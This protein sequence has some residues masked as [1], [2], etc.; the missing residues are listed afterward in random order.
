MDYGKINIKYDDL[1]LKTPS[2]KK[3]TTHDKIFLVLIS[4]ILGIAAFGFD[5]ISE[6][7]V[8]VVKRIDWVMNS[9]YDSVV[10]QN[11]VQIVYSLVALLIPF[12]IG[13]I[14][15]KLVK[16]DTDLLPFRKPKSGG[17]FVSS[18]GISFIALVV[19]NFVTSMII[20]IFQFIG[21]EF[22]GGYYEAPT[23]IPEFL[24]QVVSIAIVPAFAEE[25][26]VRGVLLQSLRKYGDVTAIFISA[27]L[28]ALMHGNFN[29]APFAF[30]MGIVIAYF[31]IVTDSLWT[32]IA[33]HCMNNFYALIVSVLSEYAI[34]FIYLVVVMS[35]NVIGCLLGILAIIWLVENKT[36]DDF[37]IKNE[38]GKLEPTLLGIV[39]PTM[40]FAIVWL[41]IECCENVS[42]VG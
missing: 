34:D 19:S 18:L 27:L 40:I 20:I 41:F 4:G 26:A 39:S 22:D 1:E 37:K 6:N 3:L 31:V 9:Y 15:I 29:Q 28:F 8:Y 32:G 30:I 23:N 16:R 24:L 21:F 2:S 12:G 35:I 14:V 38:F 13:A 17:I 5:L 7:F 10:M 11:L 25:F 33:I 42:F 36:W